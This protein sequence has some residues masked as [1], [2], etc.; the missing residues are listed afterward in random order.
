MNFCEMMMGENKIIRSIGFK[1]TFYLMVDGLILIY[2]MREGEL[3]IAVSS[4]IS[5][6]YGVDDV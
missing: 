6:T 2:L 5:N 4:Q 3:F 1:D